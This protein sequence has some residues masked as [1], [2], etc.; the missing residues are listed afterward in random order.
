LYF[1]ELSKIISEKHSKKTGL[2]YFMR[3]LFEARIINSTTTVN[4]S[5]VN[6]TEISK[7]TDMV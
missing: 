3:R 1:G 7:E 4:S 2:V 5:S 6:F